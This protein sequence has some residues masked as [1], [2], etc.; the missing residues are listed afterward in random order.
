[1]PSIKSTEDFLDRLK[2]TAANVFRKVGGEED[3]SIKINDFKRSLSEPLPDTDD[4]EGKEELQSESGE[5]R[6][7]L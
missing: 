5:V 7:G 2:T 1:M 6:V 4:Q 3:S